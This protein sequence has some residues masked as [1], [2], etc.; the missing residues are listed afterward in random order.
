MR[1][2]LAVAVLAAS[3]ALSGCER[4][5]AAALAPQEC[6]RTV[7]DIEGLRSYRVVTYECP[8]RDEAG[9]QLQHE[10][11]TMQE[12]YEYLN[13]SEIRGVHR[14]VFT[15]SGTYRPAVEQPPAP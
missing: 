10:L 13:N 12:G 1:M 15:R 9:A 14:I 2:Y 6:S 5:N 7:T 4:Q 11:E 3:L 8:F